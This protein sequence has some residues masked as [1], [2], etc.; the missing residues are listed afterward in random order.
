MRAAKESK[1][2]ARLRVAQAN[3][4]E[5]LRRE[6]VDR[7]SVITKLNVDVARITDDLTRVGA[8]VKLIET[9][10]ARREDRKP[11]RC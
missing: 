4:I 7:E 8:G 2:M 10:H 3:L 11:H 5:A 1:L 6:I 9:L